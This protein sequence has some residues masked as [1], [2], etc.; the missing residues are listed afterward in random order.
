MVSLVGVTVSVEGAPSLGCDVGVLTTVGPLSTRLGSSVGPTVGTAPIFNDGASVATL[1]G[2]DVGPSS[3]PAVGTTTA[4]FEVVVGALLAEGVLLL[5]AVV[6]K[7]DKVGTPTSGVSVI[8]ADVGEAAGDGDE[9][10][11]VEIQSFDPDPF[12]DPLPLLPGGQ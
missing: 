5:P 12:P 7:G 6:G 2:A 1:F 8:P 3:P 10:D 9:L 11:V 4:G